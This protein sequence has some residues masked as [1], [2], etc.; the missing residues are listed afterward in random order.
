MNAIFLTLGKPVQFPVSCSLQTWQKQSLCLQRMHDHQKDKHCRWIMLS[1]VLPETRN[2]ST[3]DWLSTSSSEAIKLLSIWVESCSWN[4]AGSWI[5]G[6]SWIDKGQGAS[7][8]TDNHKSTGTCEPSWANDMQV[9][10]VWLWAKLLL[11]Q[12]STCLHRRVLLHGKRWRM[13][14]LPWS[15]LCQWLRRKQWRE[16]LWRGTVK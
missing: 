16:Y 6:G 4:Y 1:H 15:D 2:A 11:Q 12:H 7:C 3:S 5:T 13:W 10:D 8:T 14:E 9:Q